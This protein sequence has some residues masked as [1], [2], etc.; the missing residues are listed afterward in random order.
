MP[1]RAHL[2][3]DK[4][5]KKIIDAAERIELDKAKHIH[6]ALCKSI[7]SQQL[8]TKVAKVI[9][10]RFL[11]LFPTKLPSPQ[12]ILDIPYEQL[13]GIG[14]SNSKTVYIQNVCQFWIDQKV[15]DAKLRKM[16]D[17]ELIN[18]LC[19]IKGI[20]RWTAEMILMFAL[21]RE[22]VFSVGDLGIQQAM[23]RLLDLDNTDKKALQAQMLAHAEQWRPYR[24]YACLHLWRWKDDK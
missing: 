5:I 24:T 6:L 8:S 13:R 21:G 3:K 4:K 20:G 12:Q 1:Y 17:E 11:D 10:Q 2:S 23:T 19:Q 9:Y 14:L 15:T 7:I 22:D 18:Y 16:D